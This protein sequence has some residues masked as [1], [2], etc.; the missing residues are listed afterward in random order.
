V[1]LLFHS[2]LG[3]GLFQSFILDTSDNIYKYWLKMLKIYIISDDDEIISFQN[4]KRTAK[5]RQSFFY[6]S[7]I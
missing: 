2:T 1:W 6:I 3:V 5:S 7:F 4:K